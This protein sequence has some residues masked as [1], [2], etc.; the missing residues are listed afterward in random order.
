MLDIKF[1]RENPEIVKQN[2]KNKFQDSKLPL[3]DEVI[4]LASSMIEKHIGD[5]PEEVSKNNKDI[6]EQKIID[7]SVAER[8][9]RK[10][11]N[12]VTGAQESISVE[13]MTMNAVSLLDILNDRLEKSRRQK[14]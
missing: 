13:G 3:V 6:E 9:A 11:N 10:F 5:T 8:M 7:S 1:L 12:K 4:E 14:R 2:I